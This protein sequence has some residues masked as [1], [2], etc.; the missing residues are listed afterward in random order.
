MPRFFIDTFDSIVAIDDV[1]HELPDEAAVR[2]VVRKT[3]ADML[4]AEHKGRPA[5]QYRAEVRDEAGLS[6]LTASVLIVIDKSP[7]R[8]A[9]KADK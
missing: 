8:K 9:A 4:G 2:E 6:I 1:G 3:W 5:T 7:E